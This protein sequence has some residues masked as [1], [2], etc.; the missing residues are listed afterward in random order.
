MRFPSEFPEDRRVGPTARSR[1]TG[2][3]GKREFWEFDRQERR[4]WIPA[5]TSPC[6]LVFSPVAMNE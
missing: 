3:T 1:A 5:D 4:N 2:F 6:L